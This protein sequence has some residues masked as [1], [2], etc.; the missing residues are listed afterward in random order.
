MITP[1]RFVDVAL[2]PVIAA[3][4][5][6]HTI[7]RTSGRATWNVTEPG[8]RSQQVAV[9]PRFKP[10]TEAQ[11]PELQHVVPPVRMGP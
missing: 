7:T 9:Q 8:D 5:F 10:G 4:R 3:I 11:T 1:G 2:L 6:A